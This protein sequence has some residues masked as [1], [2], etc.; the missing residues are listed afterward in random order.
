M[1]K[2]G[3]LWALGTMSGTS[4]DGVDAALIETDG[5]EIFAFG[6]TAYR[7]YSDAE[8][9]VLTAA[10]GRWPGQDV[11]QAEAVVMAAH[12]EVLQ[13]FER[14]ALIGFHGQTL[15]HEP[16]GRGTHQIGDGAALAETLGRAVVWDF[17]SA[18]IELGGQG[19]PLAPFY[20]FACAR[21][22][23]AQAPL[24]FLNLGGVG[25]ITWVDPRKARPEDEG[26][27]LAFDTGP[28]NAPIND[29]MMARRGEPF[30]RDGRLAKVG[31]VVDGALELFLDEPYFMQ[32]PPK[33]LDRD[34]FADMIGLVG[35]LSDADAVATLT[36][37]VAAAVL[38]GME[39]CPTP[40]E[41]MLV[42]GGGRHN[43][44]MMEMLSVALDCPVEPVEAVGLDGDMLEAQA[45]G[46][47]AVR[48]ARGLP[49]SARGTTGVRA[50]VSG[51]ILSKPEV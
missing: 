9:G 39:H 18:D 27:L 4:L 23:G 42:T 26:A 40:P 22:I 29:V 11:A 25:N 50:A 1:L 5:H 46:Y 30:D 33:S 8:R 13:G 12:R 19:A 10:L 32:M 6:E 3:R 38:R 28:A 14:G 37:M 41:R 34:A 36:G 24:A 49:T 44:V 16:R 43:P 21:Y 47:L 7:A 2:A 20:H 17:R 51:G 35:E 31:N 45:F 15:A 48:V